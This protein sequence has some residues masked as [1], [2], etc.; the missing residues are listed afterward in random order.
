MQALIYLGVSQN[1]GYHFRGPH[2]MDYSVLGVYI[3]V[4]LSWESTIYNCN[5]GPAGTMIYSAFGC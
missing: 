3:G 5:R 4:P 1:H 2:N